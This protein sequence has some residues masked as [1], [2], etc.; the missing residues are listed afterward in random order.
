MLS[1][2]T[3]LIAGVIG[4]LAFTNRNSVQGATSCTVA[5]QRH[6]VVIQ[7][8]TMSPG[9]VDAHVCDTLTITNQDAKT[10]KIGFGEHDKH[11]AYDGVS[12]RVLSSGQSFT[13]TLNE[14]G[15]VHFH[16]HFQEEVEASFTV[17]R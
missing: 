12:E 4:A 9:H 5:G 8:G 10:R 14:I 11:V 17:L 7:A 6:T 2:A 3:L 13:I 16:D 1:V 15:E